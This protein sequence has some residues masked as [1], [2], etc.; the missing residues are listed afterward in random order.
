[1]HSCFQIEQWWIYN[2]RRSDHFFCFYRPQRSWGKVI[3]PEAYVKNSV[4]GGGGGVSQHALQVS[5]PTPRGEVEGSGLGALQAHTQGEVEG[6]GLGSLQAHFPGE[7]LQVQTLGDLQAH[8]WGVSR[9]T[10]GGGLQA[11]TWGVSQHVLRQ[12][13]HSRQ[14]LVRAVRI[15]LECILVLKCWS[16]IGLALPSGVSWISPCSRIM[17]WISETFGVT[18]HCQ[19]VN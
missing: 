14:L 8:T 19:L 1:M 15:L 5:S 13:P 16:K 4:H 11:H 18:L 6:S 3:F 7:G 12:T 9:P 10:P 2:S 17:E